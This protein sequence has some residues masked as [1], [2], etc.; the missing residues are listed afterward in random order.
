MKREW[1]LMCVVSVIVLGWACVHESE[2]SRPV[3]RTMIGCVVGGNLYS[4]GNRFPGEEKRSLVVYRITVRDLNL[5]PY[6]GKKIRVQGR[7]LPGD[8]FTPDPSTLSVLGPCDNASSK[9]IRE[10]SP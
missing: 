7:L 1:I 4:V 3:S 6:E 10:Q 2:A 9:A 5:A 8:R